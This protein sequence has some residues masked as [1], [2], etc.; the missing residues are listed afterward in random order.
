MQE[1]FLKQ[2]LT[3]PQRHRHA[4]GTETARRKREIRFH[5]PFKFQKGLVIEDDIVKIL[6]ADARFRKAIGNGI[7][8]ETRVMLL[9]RK[10]LFLGGGGDVPVLHQSRRAVMIKG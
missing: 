5:Q 2:L 9:A 3:S 4:E 1:L 8:W 10:S 7:F 6:Q